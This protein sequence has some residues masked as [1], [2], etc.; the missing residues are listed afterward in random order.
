MRRAVLSVVGTV[1][2]LVLLLSYKTHA[3]TAL[4]RPAALAP[5]TPGPT[6]AAGPTPAPTSSSSSASTTAASRTIDGDPVDT[7][8][9]TV[10][11]RVTTKA[12]R[13]VDVQ[14]LQ[15]PNGSGRDI[16]IDNIAVPELVQETLQAQNAHIDMISG[17]TYTST[18]YIQSLQ[19]AL[20]RM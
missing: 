19:S 14:P 5:P 10:Q 17:A 20:D 7:Q 12:G 16:M 1:A 8:F 2:G 6:A 13:I 11:V 18:G 15:L 4:L 3:S 9:G